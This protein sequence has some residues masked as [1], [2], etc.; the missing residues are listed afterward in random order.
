MRGRACARL[1]DARLNTTA[2]DLFDAAEFQRFL[3]VARAAKFCHWGGDCYAFGL[4]A[5]G[6]IDLC[7]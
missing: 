7:V 6:Y 1:A 2:A 4:V 5:S 3:N